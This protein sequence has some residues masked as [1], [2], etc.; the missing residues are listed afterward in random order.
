MNT[1]R[2]TLILGGVAVA[3]ALAG[4]LNDT[5]G[6]ETQADATADNG[7]ATSSESGDDG[8]D[9]TDSD[10]SD[11]APEAARTAG[12]ATLEAITDGEF[13]EAAADAPT[14]FL[15][16]RSRDERRN[17][18]ERL[19]QPDRIRS[20]EFSASDTDESLATAFDELA[21]T[22]GTQTYQLEYDV[23]F[24]TQ[25]ER[26]ERP[27]TVA[28]AQIDG[29]WYTWVDGDGWLTLR[30]QAAVDVSREDP[31]TVTITLMDRSEL[32]TV[33]VRGDGIDEPADYRLE[34]VGDRLTIT[35]ADVGSGPFDVVASIEGPDSETATTLETV[36]LTD[37]SAW[38]DVEEITLEGRTVSWEGVEP[39]HIEGIENPT[40]V[41]QKGR[42]YT[43]TVTN[44]DGAIHKFELRDED[45][46]VVDDYETD[47]LEGEG[48]EQE[49]T[50]TASDELASYA[51]APHES[52]MD[53][54][55]TVVDSFDGSDS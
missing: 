12:R 32:T 40:L 25:G 47:L 49:L 52:L 14:A 42:A 44:G 11:G 30:P 21:A 27:V 33:F 45:D 50:V 6:D 16:D 7:T 26:Y 36:S 43:I 1:N 15:E 31:G 34:S 39:A 48:A 5:R 24:E 37:P 54:D 19:W 22:D 51:C 35:V 18:Y 2:R 23:A 10:T 53:G 29:D 41:L 46:A 17:A 3:S 28:A 38:A 20:I 55:I 9:T 8:T 4:C 13:D